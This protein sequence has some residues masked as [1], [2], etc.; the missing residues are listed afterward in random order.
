MYLHAWNFPQTEVEISSNRASVKKC[1][2]EKNQNLKCVPYDFNRVIL[3]KSSK[4]D[5][6]DYINASYVDVSC[7]DFQVAARHAML[8]SLI[9]LSST[10]H[11]QSLSH[12]NAYIVTQG[13]LEETV[14]DFWR[15][16]WQEDVSC[17][18]MLTKVSSSELSRIFF[19][20]FSNMSKLHPQTFDFTKVMCVQYWPASKE[21]DETYD[22]L[23]IGIVE[24]EELAN[25]CVR[26][27]RI[28]KLNEKH[29]S[30]F[31]IVENFICWIIK[32]LIRYSHRVHRPL[33]EDRRAN[34]SS[35]PL[36]SIHIALDSIRQ[37]NFGIQTTRS[38]DCW[39]EIA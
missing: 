3:K 24:E 18:V 5:D 31:V 7:S 26:T 6:A 38:N 30:F 4:T 11:R 37:L 35:I 29:V 21:N 34:C 17:I 1:N 36:H 9:F 22:D 13:P 25:Y 23:H 16:I 32:Y 14:K 12:S 39:F 10:I 28:Y 20:I 19:F 33:G 2:L 8:H 15:M 27:F